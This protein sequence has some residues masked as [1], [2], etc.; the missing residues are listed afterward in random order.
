V[1]LGALEL[2]PG[3]SGMLDVS[4]SNSV[5]V[6]RVVI[7]ISAG[8]ELSFEEASAVDEAEGGAVKLE[9]GVNGGAKVTLDM[10]VGSIAPD[11]RGRVVLRLKVKLSSE[12]S[13]TDSL[14]I[15]PTSVEV[16]DEKGSPLLSLGTDGV[17]VVSEAAVIK[18]DATGDGVVNIMDVLQIVKYALGE[19]T[20]SGEALQSSD[21][22]GDGEVNIIDVLAC[23]KRAL[24]E[25]TQLAGA[26]IAL[27]LSGEAVSR[28][29]AGLRQLDAAE[30]LYTDV[31]RLL[32]KAGWQERLPKSYS[33]SQNY[34]NPFNP[35]TVISY[36]IPEG[37]SV[38]VRLD[39]YNLRGQ[40][41]KTL[42]NE[43]REPGEYRVH[44]DGRDK[45]GD[46]APSGVY[47]Y[48]IRAGEYIQAR[49]MV[50]LR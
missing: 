27:D 39:V 44:W 1:S 36:A 18:G 6:K 10:G 19:Q 12:G 5:P 46:Q 30:E 15:H 42:V 22:N 26:G 13:E 17:V 49:K 4:L 38:Q 3:G 11:F 20:A 40:M 35:S 37:R 21:L 14:I 34:P 16:L 45:Q 8:R 9:P 31:K 47:L 32:A 41:I 29:Y 50:I 43:M 33:L 48:R 2:S 25:G 28:L 23:V 7:S 24:E